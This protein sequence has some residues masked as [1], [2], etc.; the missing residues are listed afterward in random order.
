MPAKIAN[1]VN[2]VPKKE[3]SAAF[4]NKSGSDNN[5]KAPDGAPFC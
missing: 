3:V 4:A 2:I 1:I 5:K